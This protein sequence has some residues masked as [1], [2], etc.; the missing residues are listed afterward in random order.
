MAIVCCICGK[1]Q[2][3]WI[4]DYPLSPE[5]SEYRLCMEC[6]ERYQKIQRVE[7]DED[8]VEEI[9]F[10]R[11]EGLAVFNKLCACMADLPGA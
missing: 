8:A 4:I 1:K 9:V 7:N 2:S 11:L 5:L 6:G 3:G 10:Y